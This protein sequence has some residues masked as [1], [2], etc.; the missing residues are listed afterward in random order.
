MGRYVVVLGAQWGDEGKGKIV[1]MLAA[2][3]SVVVRF[4]G[5]HNA[6]HTLVLNGQRTALHLVP[7]G[8]LHP[9]T[10]CMLGNGVAVS[11]HAL[12]RE[13]EG[14]E[15][16]GVSV[17]ER[18]TISPACPLLLPSHAALDIAQEARRQGQRLG[19]TGCG[20]GP[21][22]E[23]KA[24]RRGLRCGDLSD[25]ERLAEGIRELV[26]YHNFLLVEYY[27]AES[28]DIPALIDACLR[29]GEALRPML[30]DV[31]E[32]LHRARDDNVLFE[33]AQGSELD[34]DHG[35]YPFVTSSNTTAAA[36]ALGSGC[37][38]LHLDAV[39]GVTKSYATRVG[40]GPFATELSDAIG[41]ALL[42]RG[43]EYGTTTGR[44]RRCG[45]LDAAALSRAVRINS[46]TGLALTKLDVLDAFERIA[47]CVAHDGERPVYETMPGW[48]ESTAGMNAL[49]QLPDTARAYIERIEAL[50]GVPVDL[51]STGQDRAATAIVRD[52]YA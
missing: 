24:A 28:V 49:A 48:Q 23:D 10:R 45:W 19:T 43:Q 2:K 51:V 31:G 8:I 30:A 5:G 44:Q 14:L 41:A 20:I 12:L 33:G 39:L 34:L 35:T 47:L 32:A 16:A 50:T 9:G 38:P 42:E 11:P 37:G 3:A 21:A 17:R 15:A 40:A 22:Y 25:P 29:H 6:G 13:I 18:L 26:A 46:I 4:Q 52:P 27:G 7:S 1:D 36:A